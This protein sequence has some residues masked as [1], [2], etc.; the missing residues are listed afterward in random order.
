[1]YYNIHLIFCQERNSKKMKDDN[2]PER[3]ALR[4][5]IATEIAD[6][7]DT[8][9]LDFIYKLIINEKGGA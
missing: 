5:M 7:T 6:C 9:F 4:Q 2:D 8:S 1:M 3:M